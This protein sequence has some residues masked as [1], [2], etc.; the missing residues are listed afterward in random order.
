[1]DGAYVE[2][3]F[4]SINQADVWVYTGTDRRNI[5]SYIDNEEKAF[6]GTP[7]RIP[8]SEYILIV[9]QTYYEGPFGAVTFGY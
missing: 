7:F 2:L 5:T 4:Y 9:A 6:P 1:M 8:I 3:I